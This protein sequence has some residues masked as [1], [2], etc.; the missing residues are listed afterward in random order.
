MSLYNESPAGAIDPTPTV[1]M[2][3]LIDEEKHITT[4][5]HFSKTPGDAVILLLGELG[6]ELGAAS[7]S[8]VVARPKKVRAL[9]R[10]WI[11]AKELPCRTPCVRS[12]SPGSSRAPTI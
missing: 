5:S 4:Q 10:G 7:I 9:C 11:S 1:G 8:K 3:G 2:V 6:D 12:S